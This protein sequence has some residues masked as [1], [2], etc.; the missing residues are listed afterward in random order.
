LWFLANPAPYH[1]VKECPPITIKGIKDC[2]SKEKATISACPEGNPEEVFTFEAYVVPDD[3]FRD[4]CELILARQISIDSQGFCKAFVKDIDKQGCGEQPLLPFPSTSSQPSLNEGSQQDPDGPCPPLSP[5]MVRE[6]L[7][8]KKRSLS[9]SSSPM[10]E[11]DDFDLTKSELHLL[12]PSK[13][14]VKRQRCFRV[15][16]EKMIQNHESLVDLFT[17]EKIISI[18]KKLLDKV[19]KGPGITIPY[20]DGM[21]A[22]VRRLH[23]DERRDTPLQDFAVEIHFNEKTLKQVKSEINNNPQKKKEFNRLQQQQARG[24]DYSKKLIREL[25]PEFKEQ[26]DLEIDQFLRL[27]YWELATLAAKPLD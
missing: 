15:I 14:E 10:D 6:A 3:T 18:T 22:K 2:V 25:A 7:D 11:Y 26:M 16:D 21:V 23:P 19:S 12:G 8:S 24:Y 13:D 5:S 17:E 20:T 1:Q 27:G 4:D 9:L